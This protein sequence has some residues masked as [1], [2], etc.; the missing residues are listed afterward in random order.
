MTLPDSSIGESCLLRAARDAVQGQ[1][2]RPQEA[3]TGA[4][5]VSTEPAGGRGRGPT[6][7]VLAAR[8][9]FTPSSPIR[10]FA[11][12]W[13]LVGPDQPVWRRAAGG[14]EAK[15]SRHGRR[16]ASPAVRLL[17]CRLGRD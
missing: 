16:T 14:R 2:S 3:M 9:A 4:R 11:D 15:R 13:A 17:L 5:K 7:S 10:E 1:A 6:L 8:Y 12:A